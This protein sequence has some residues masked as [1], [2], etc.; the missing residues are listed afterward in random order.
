MTTRTTTLNPNFS[1]IG[2]Y[3]QPYPGKD[4]VS[5]MQRRLDA[6]SAFMLPSATAKPQTPT[7]SGSTHVTFC[8]HCGTCACGAATLKPKDA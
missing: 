7:C 4:D 8:P 5:G 1:E 3:S 2:R 6:M